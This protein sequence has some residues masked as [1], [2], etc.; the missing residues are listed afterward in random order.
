V[1]VSEPDVPRAVGRAFQLLELVAAAGEVNLTN[2]AQLAGLTPSTALRHLRALEALG[3][4]DRDRDGIYSAGP[5]VLRLAAAARG[6]GPLARLVAAAQPVLDE[7]TAA[8]G[9]SGY[10][11]VAEGDLALY[12]A[13]SESQRSIRHVGWVGRTVPLDGTAVG[14]ALLGATGPQHRTD[15]IE[16]DIAAV[17]HAVTDGDRVVA[18]LS[19]IGPAHRMDAAA[20]VAAGEAL[21]RAAT[22]LA[23]ALGLAAPPSRQESTR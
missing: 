16:P 3:Y 18:A 23:A 7:L 2:A 19:V 11:A 22:Q 17:A 6:D 10:L 15:T 13:T 1:P 9:E 4:V 14:A 12:V 8:T 21:A 20:V 5:A